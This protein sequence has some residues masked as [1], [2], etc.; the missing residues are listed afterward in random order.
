[1]ARRRLFQRHASRR[2][3]WS[4]LRGLALTSGVLFFNFHLHFR[5][6]GLERPII[7]EGSEL[8]QREVSADLENILGYSFEDEDDG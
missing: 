8:V 3:S 1:M 7:L 2:G 4:F 6:F 5:L